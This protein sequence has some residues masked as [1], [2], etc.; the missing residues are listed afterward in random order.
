MQSTGPLR[1][2]TTIPMAGS[3]CS[4]LVDQLI[5]IM[6]LIKT[7]EPEF[8]SLAFQISFKGCPYPGRYFIHW[9]NEENEHVKQINSQL[10]HLSHKLSLCSHIT[11]GRVGFSR[12][13]AIKSPRWCW[14]SNLQ[15]SDPDL[16]HFAA[17]PYQHDL[18]ISMAPH[19][20]AYIKLILKGLSKVTS[21]TSEVPL[22]NHQD[23]NRLE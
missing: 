16:L 10:I 9:V 19:G 6:K 21:S 7:I 22:S 14:V 8:L 11:W 4:C 2:D 17:V 15:P 1:E 12:D 5:W 23:K 20:W 13:S 18:A 3:H